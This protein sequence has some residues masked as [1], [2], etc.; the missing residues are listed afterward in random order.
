MKIKF[1]K[2][3]FDKYKKVLM[4]E[5]KAIKT[6][7]DL[8]KFRIKYL[9][10]EG[11][12]NN[13]LIQIPK[14]NEKER[15]IWGKL[16]NNLK[17]QIEKKI[18]E[19]KQKFAELKIKEQL[20]KEKIDITAPFKKVLAGHLHPLTI[21]QKKIFEIFEGMG[22]EIVLGP[23]VENDYNN[24]DALNIPKWHPARDLW[25]TFW[26]KDKSLVIAKDEVDKF[27]KNLLLRTHTSPVQIRY[28]KKNNPPFRIISPGRCF[29]YE[30]T[31]SKHDIQFHQIEGLMVGQDI[32]LANLKAILQDFFNNFFEKEIEVR[33]R[34]S[35]FP[36]V[37]PGIEVDIECFKCGGKGCLLC[38][39]EGWL[40]IMGAGMVHQNVFKS[41]G[42]PPKQWQ[43][44]AFGM[45]LERLTMLKYKIDDIRLFHSA[46]LRFI[47][48][49]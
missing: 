26:L 34:P 36:F 43:G 13:A 11:I 2:K 41:V 16:I 17:T 24:F 23:E 32:S 10:R 46:D 12:F 38:A 47:N 20:R 37:E 7:D 39:K 18:E 30:A 3:Q 6:E 1:T 45:G 21:I 9:G 4:E 29:R 49:F 35:Y 48:Q 14:L 15:K 31:D 40:E 5:Y 42:Y 25:D 33:F 44:F 8:E 27:N 22:F 28:M 19:K